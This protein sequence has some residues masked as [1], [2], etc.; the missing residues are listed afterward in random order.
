MKMS[1]DVYCTEQYNLDGRSREYA[2]YIDGE[3]SKVITCDSIIKEYST[4][5]NVFIDYDQEF[6]NAYFFEN[7]ELVLGLQQCLE[8]DIKI[9]YQYGK[10]DVY[11]TSK[12]E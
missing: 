7:G 5:Y 6:E 9:T 8:I 2:I 3:L 10:C 4:I 12:G 1:E 11:V